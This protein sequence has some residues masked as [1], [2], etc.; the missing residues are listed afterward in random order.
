MI[1]CAII[2]CLLSISIC[3]DGYTIT[4][5]AGTGTSDF[6]G[7]GGDATSADLSEPSRV[8]VNS[9]GDVYISDSDNSHIRKI[10]YETAIQLFVFSNIVTSS[11]INDLS[12]ITSIAG[13]DTS[14][15]YSG[16]GGDATAA[17]LDT[18]YGVTL[19]SSG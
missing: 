10:Y 5:I 6:S 7:D 12:F 16:D 15:G 17:D 8:F 13:Y 9:N 14:G 2:L 1:V 18:P 3:V 11:P 19:D 4:T